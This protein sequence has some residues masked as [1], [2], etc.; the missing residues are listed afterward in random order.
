[1]KKNAAIISALLLTALSTVSFASMTLISP[2]GLM[3]RNYTGPITSLSYAPGMQ[4]VTVVINTDKSLVFYPHVGLVSVTF[5][6]DDFAF[7]SSISSAVGEYGTFNL[8]T[9]NVVDNFQVADANL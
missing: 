8:T 3:P 7:G 6:G 4:S 2:K 1:M 5:D 9:N